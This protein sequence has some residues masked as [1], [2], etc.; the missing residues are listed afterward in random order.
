LVARPGLPSAHLTAYRAGAAVAGALPGEV[1]RSLAEGLG[2]MAGRLSAVDSLARWPGVEPLVRRRAVVVARLRRVLSCVEG[3]VPDERRLG[4]MVDASFASYGR[5]WAESLRLPSL[6]ADEVE[7]GMSTQ[8]FE[9]LDAAIAAGRGTILALPHLG[10]WDWGGRFLVGTDRPVSV[11]VEALRHPDVFAWFVEFRRRLGME[12][13]P[14][15]PQAGTA[16][17]R[18]LRANRVLCLLSDRVVADTPGVETQFFGVPTRLPAGPVTLAL[19]TGAVLL[20]A[21]VYFGPRAAEHLAVVRAPLE[22]RR[23]GRGGLRADVAA[24]TQA[25]AG[26]LEALIAREPTQWHLMQPDSRA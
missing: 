14:I 25:L 9:H 3:R 4:R 6:T 17:L 16:S 26:E 18:A 11:V 20:P 2:G 12:V 1:A 8:G 21:A 19:R 7:A 10:G 22:L 13:I 5:Y 15:G 23:S 24:G